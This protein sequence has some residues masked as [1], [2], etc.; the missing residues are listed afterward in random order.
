MP[1]FILIDGDIALFQPNFGPAVVTVQPGKLHGSG[2]ATCYG[3]PVC[4]QGD[5]SGVQVPGCPYISGAF[6]TPGSG[7]LKISALGSD[8]MA[9]KIASGEK[10]VLLKGSSFQAVFEVQSPAINP[11]GVPD[12]MPQYLGGS[13]QFI[14]TNTQYRAS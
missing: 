8:Q 13:G 9:R 12:P 3:K 14:T 4:V 2:P 11:L 5:E 7:T 1:D 6:V 10:P